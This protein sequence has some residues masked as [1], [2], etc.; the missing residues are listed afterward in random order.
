MSRTKS[1][2]KNLYTAIIGQSLGIVISF[3]ARRVFLFYLNEEYLGLNG[4]FSNILTI[5]SL[6]ELGIGPAINFALY[7]PLAEHR[8]EQ[9]KSLMALYKK[10]YILIG[11]CIAVIGLLFTPYYKLFLNEVPDLPQLTLIYWLFLANTSIS[12]FFSYKQA[13]IICDEKRYIATTFHYIFY[14]L[15]NV[16]QIIALIATH[17]YILFLVIQVAFTLIQNVNISHQA[18]KL[19]PYLK[20][21]NTERLSKETLQGIKKN[22]FAMVCHKIGG[23]VVL[24][25]DNLILSKFV[26][27]TAVGLYSNY[28]LITN[29]LNQIIG[30]VFTSLTAS[31]GNLNASEETEGRVKLQR[32]FERVFFLN[33][34]MYGFSAC[35]LWGLFNPFITLWLGD[36]L[37]FD[38]FT[39]LII[40]I[41]FYLYG[42][43]RTAIM[44]REATGVF[45]F[46][47]YKPLAEAAINIVVSIILAKRMGTAGVFLG[48]IISTLLACI[49]VE[50][51]VVY[52]HVFHT[53][54][55][56]YCARFLK[57]ALA[58]AAAGVLITLMG[59]A[60]HIQNAVL[61]FVVRCVLCAA[62][63]NLLF[64]V[65]FFR[66]DEFRFFVEFLTHGLKR[67][68]KHFSK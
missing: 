30:Q 23:M 7:K 29:A 65:F 28:Y 66:T 45:Y 11:C 50:P 54:L 25:T 56:S 34:W 26:G 8:Y 19:Y 48:T 9:I 57:Y 63:P 2:L 58:T 4:L 68:A 5:F 49:L 60:L 10:F 37:L 53:G 35:C 44:Y 59:Q 14:F 43:R 51:Y 24:S 3:V 18:D 31:V 33:F 41:N 21:K 62:V 22:V 46:D 12:Y 6:V 64:F 17:N 42:I 61:D 67:L 55:G 52:K 47:R 27:L 13:L 39:V 40:V 1:S 15:T 38:N 36:K 32:T 16:I 20:E